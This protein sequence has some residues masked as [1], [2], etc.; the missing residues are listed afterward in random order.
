M[1]D[2]LLQL[3]GCHLRAASKPSGELHTPA[4][5]CRLPH[6]CGAVHRGHQAWLPPDWGLLRA[7]RLP[8]GCGL[9]LD[10]LMP[11]GEATVQWWLACHRQEGLVFGVQWMPQVC[12]LLRP[13][14]THRLQCI[15]VAKFGCQQKADCCGGNACAKDRASAVAGTCAEVSGQGTCAAAPLVS[16]FWPR[17]HQVS[18]CVVAT[19][20]ALTR[21]S[22]LL[23]P[24]AVRPRQR[25]WL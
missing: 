19:R 16:A 21:R 9:Q 17:P 12:W 5:C 14:C 11:D 24:P 3:K 10:G 20:L 25:L 23:R 18:M 6:G 13:L 22:W 2:G 1:P 15:A 7:K 4:S 8:E